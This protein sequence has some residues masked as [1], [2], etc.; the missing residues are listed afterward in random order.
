[1]RPWPISSSGSCCLLLPFRLGPWWG[2][3]RAGA[4]FHVCVGGERSSIEGPGSG[5]SGDKEQGSG[6]SVFHVCVPDGSDGVAEGEAVFGVPRR[7]LGAGV[8]VEQRSRPEG[9]QGIHTQQDRC[10]AKYSLI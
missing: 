2:D 3:A 4:G 10:C 6:G 8:R 5:G 1:M 7:P 9:C